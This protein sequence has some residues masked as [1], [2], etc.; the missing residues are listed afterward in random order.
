MTAESGLATR[1]TRRL[2][3]AFLV[4]MTLTHL[5]TRF[6]DFVDSPVGFVSSAE[7]RDCSQQPRAAIAKVAR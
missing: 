5:P 3:W 4:W 6:S 7:P 1:S 2:A